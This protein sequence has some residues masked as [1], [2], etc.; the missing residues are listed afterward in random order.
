MNDISNLENFFQF[1]FL[2]TYFIVDGLVTLR[3]ELLSKS[4][5]FVQAE[6]LV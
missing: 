4:K 6:Q 3:V 5:V 2:Q 1:F